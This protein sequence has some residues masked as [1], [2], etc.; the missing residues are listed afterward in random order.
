MR[1]TLNLIEKI[2]KLHERFHNH[3]IH[4]FQ[5]DQ[6]LSRALKDAFEEFINKTNYVVRYLAKYAHSFMIK[7]GPSEGKTKQNK[8][9]WFSFFLSNLKK[10]T[11]T[12]QKK[13]AIHQNPQKFQKNLRD[14][15]FTPKIPKKKP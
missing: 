10:V 13:F 11:I 6:L 3:T 7:G 14:R 15:I 2:I 8:K 12:F 1:S 5:S 4:D 9:N